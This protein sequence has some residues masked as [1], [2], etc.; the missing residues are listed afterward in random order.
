[1]TLDELAAVLRV[2]QGPFFDGVTSRCGCRRIVLNAQEWAEHVAEVLRSVPGIAIVELPRGNA[3]WR[4]VDWQPIAG[5]DM[6]AFKGQVHIDEASN[7]PLSPVEARK[8]AAAL[9]AAAR[10]AETGADHE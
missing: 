3:D 2:H 7:E 5:W 1:M 4:S 6:A 10:A 9:L 8:V